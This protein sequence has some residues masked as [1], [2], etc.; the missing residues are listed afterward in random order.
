MLSESHGD[1]A[2]KGWAPWAPIAKRN[3]KSSSFAVFP[4]PKRV[5]RY[6]ARIWLNSLGQ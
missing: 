3:W 6:W 1:L 2:Q 4:S 5:W